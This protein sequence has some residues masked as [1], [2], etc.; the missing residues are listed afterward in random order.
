MS[1]VSRPRRW[2][3]PDAA[4][5]PAVSPGAA[6]TGTAR[7]RRGNGPD[8]GGVWRGRGCAGARSKG[9]ALDWDKLRIFHAAADAGSFTHA[10]EKLE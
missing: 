3:W 7:R 1:R 4:L 10:G 8:G 6:R 9:V 5:V 2:N